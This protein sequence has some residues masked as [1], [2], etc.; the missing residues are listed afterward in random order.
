MENTEPKS[1]T[2]QRNYYVA[3]G[4]ELVRFAKYQYT[5]QQLKIFNYA[6]SKIRIT[7]NPGKWYE[8][9][10]DELCSI[11]GLDIDSG[12]YYY[13]TIKQDLQKLT[14]RRWVTLA[15]R[16]AT[17]SVLSDA[18]I[19]PLS[20]TVYIKFHEKIEPYLMEL[21]ENYTQYKLADILCFKSKHT[22][23][24]FEMLKSYI[25]REEIESGKEKECCLS[26]DQLRA[27]LDV[28]GY[29]RWA[30]LD[31]CVLKVAVD[32]I[33]NH[34][35]TLQ[36]EYATN[37]SGRNVKSVSFYVKGKM[38]TQSYITRQKNREIL[39]RRESARKK[40]GAPEM[41]EKWKIEHPEG[42]KTDCLREMGLTKYQIDKYWDP[43]EYQRKLQK[44][45]ERRNKK[46]KEE[47][48]QFVYE[49]IASIENLMQMSETMKN[50][51]GYDEIQKKIQQI[52]K[53]CKT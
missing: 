33:N 15:D 53:R 23:R 30:E 12:G 24:L 34:S 10:I 27:I 31:R 46:A 16:E 52:K 3:K 38:P 32:E 44:R 43:E 26:V 37:K 9:S 4:N 22:I 47:L 29:K 39:D 42:T 8:L 35:E 48:N 41:I 18:E 2:T 7:D 28:E 25:T 19:V 14:T 20:G 6:V 45:E 17:I 40:R 51:N 5:A 13:R 49:N 21:Q 11:C 36:V 50:R 1:I